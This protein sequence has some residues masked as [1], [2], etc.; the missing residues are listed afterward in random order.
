MQARADSKNNGSLRSY[1]DTGSRTPVAC[2]NYTML[3]LVHNTRLVYLVP[4]LILLTLQS[5]FTRLV[6]PRGGC[7]RCPKQFNPTAQADARCILYEPDQ[8]SGRLGARSSR[9]LLVEGVWI[10][11]HPIFLGSFDTVLNGRGKKMTP[12]A[13]FGHGES[14]PSLPPTIT[15]SSNVRGQA[16]YYTHKMRGSVPYT[17]SESSYSYKPR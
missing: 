7:P 17:I 14:N 12:P 16:V 10:E 11:I 1:S 13:V 2:W 6:F 4:Y 3:S 8:D 5:S 15:F 9:T